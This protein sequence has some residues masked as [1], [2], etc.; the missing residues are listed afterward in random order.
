MIK[1]AESGVD[2]VVEYRARGRV[3]LDGDADTTVMDK[4]E[5]SCLSSGA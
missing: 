5:E 2:I 4:V 3:Q 1:I